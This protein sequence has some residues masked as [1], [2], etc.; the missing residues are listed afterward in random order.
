MKPLAM[1]GILL[2]TGMCGIGSAY[3]LTSYV[4]KGDSVSTTEGAGMV[5]TNIQEAK[6]ETEP[7]E[8][9]QKIG[10]YIATF[11]LNI[12]DFS[13]PEKSAAVLE[14]L[15]T[16]HEEREIPVEVFLTTTMV[17]VFSSEYPELWN[18]LTTS[19]MVDISYHIRPPVPYHNV[20]AETVDWA[21][22]SDSEIYDL[23]STYETHGLDLTQ[24]TPTEDPGSFAKLT[25]L[26][27]HPARCV[28][29][30]AGPDTARI[31]HEVFFDLGATCLVD[32]AASTN[33]GEYQ[34]GLWVR[35]QHVDIKFFEEIETSPED[36]LSSAKETAKNIQG[37]EAPYFL[38]VKMHDNDFFAEDSAW[39]TVF[40]APGAR[41]DGPPYDTS[42]TSPLLSENEQEAI[43]NA[44]IKL[45]DAAKS[46]S[47][48][49]L[50][51]LSSVANL[52]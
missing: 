45:L 18:H 31:L 5:D 20:A 47:S 27:G 30:A 32:N 39:T 14:E 37:A 13:Y 42:I 28:G 41:R 9:D 1:G 16:A 36:V 17:D 26:L 34:E 51:N 6:S 4:G 8:T 7:K 40:L 19:P 12:Q 35:P 21:S 44:Y 11:T 50:L 49:T 52:E 15:I 38:N 46:D 10:K 29:T 22:M 2:I 33:L 43:L 3:A 23:I 25:T 48:L 24:G